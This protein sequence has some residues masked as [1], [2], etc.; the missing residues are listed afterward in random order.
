VNLSGSDLLGLD[1]LSLVKV[2]SLKGNFGSY[3]V[4]LIG[5]KGSTPS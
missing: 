4:L 2:M 3:T 1:C 5:Q